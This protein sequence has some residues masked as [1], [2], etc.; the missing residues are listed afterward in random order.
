MPH[1]LALLDR[2]GRFRLANI[3][4]VRLHG[5]DTLQ[6]LLG[7][8]LVELVAEEDRDRVRDALASLLADHSRRVLNVDFLTGSGIRIPV[9]AH[10]G[11]LRHESDTS[12]MGFYCMSLD[13]RDQKAAREALRASERK[14]Q[15]LVE[16]IH[17]ILLT[18][19]VHGIVTYISPQVARYGF[20]P[21]AF[22]GRSIL[23]HVVPEDREQTRMA[24]ERSMTR[25]DEFL[26][27][28]RA[29]DAQGRLVFFEE[30]GRVLRDDQ[31]KIIGMQSLLRDVTERKQAQRDLAFQAALLD[32]TLDG[33]LALDVHGTIVYANAAAARMDGY[34]RSELLGRKIS[35]LDAPEDAAAV[36]A[37]IREILAQGSARFTV[38]HVRKDGSRYPVEV[39][40][41]RLDLN[42]QRFI[43]A[44][45][46]DITERLEAET[47]LRDSR[48]SYRQIVENINDGLV[49]L[50]G[51]GAIVELNRPMVILTG[52]SELELM[53]KSLSA[54][55]APGHG[56]AYRQHLERLRAQGTLVFETVLRV[57]SGAEV[58][59]SVSG[60]EMERGG[61]PCVQCLLRD[62]SR[63]RHMEETLRLSE[64]RYRTLVEE[65]SEMIC[66]WTYDTTLTFANAAFARFVGIPAERLI[67]MK[68][69]GLSPP[70][71]RLRAIAWQ[72][73]R[74]GAQPQATDTS[75][76]KRRDGTPRWIEWVDSV[77][78]VGEGKLREIQSI[79]RD[80]T[81]H[82]ALEEQV[83]RVSEIE[84]EKLRRDLHD[85][86]CQMLSGLAML[87]EDLCVRIRN[88]LPAEADVA[89]DIRNAA[90][91]T[92][93]IAR[94]VARELVPRTTSYAML[95]MRLRSLA[96]RL[97]KV[98]GILCRVQVSRRAPTQDA[99]TLTQLFLIAQEAA[100]N[101]ARH[102]GA[103][104]VSI[105][106]H[107]A[108]GDARLT[109]EDNGRGIPPS[110][111]ERGMGLAIMRARAGLIGWSFR[112]GKGSCGGT[113]VECRSPAAGRR[114]GG[115]PD[116]ENIRSQPRQRGG[117]RPGG[118]RG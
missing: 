110:A 84:R 67:G 100:V 69:D 86:V 48:E 71:P 38:R 82:K 32:N 43:V 47:H 3:T 12:P 78:D 114:R 23:E 57:R 101:A 14:Y 93:Q 77:V 70:R 39:V 75:L 42:G 5:V 19:D 56:P 61:T 108:R 63:Q 81:E 13:R 99:E 1:G 10:F 102:A 111:E 26:T 30:M 24:F 113:V 37:R 96:R 29:R 28:F 16:R 89:E 94:E 91:E 40:A 54:L 118:T 72:L 15:T 7:R 46:R 41:R 25:G 50:D 55:V 92:L 59:V 80:V 74:R 4:A 18:C 105:T 34:A 115:G 35:M 65:Q 88:T 51:T 9:V 45:N 76:W 58:W 66:R 36:P 53:G 87:A 103:R 112:I 44:V 104:T 2:E 20:R 109:V 27:E 11:V 73:T 6:E 21:E 90:Q 33:I 49:V 22:L 68:W 62:I 79:G 31:G 106:L 98:Y 107:V 116:H 83:A 97:R 17:E 85:G 52:Y 95:V 8:P 60:R 117:R 64:R